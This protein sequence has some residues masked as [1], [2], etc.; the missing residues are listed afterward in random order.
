MM[1]P[2]LFPILFVLCLTVEGVKY[3]HNWV[4]VRKDNETVAANF[5]DVSGIELIS[6][7]FANSGSIPAGFSNGTAGPTDHHVMGST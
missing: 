4:L 2:L 5:P 6:P 1:L 3:G 7:A